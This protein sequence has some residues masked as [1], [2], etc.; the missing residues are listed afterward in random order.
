MGWILF[1]IGLWLI[2]FILCL[3]LAYFC[4]REERIDDKTLGALF[5]YWTAEMERL[6]YWPVMVPFVNIFMV[7]IFTLKYLYVL[8]KDKELW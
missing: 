6:D 2:P 1:L 4:W 3:V 5:G 8:F 7:L